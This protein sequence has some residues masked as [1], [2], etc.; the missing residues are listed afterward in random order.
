MVKTFLLVNVW[1]KRQMRTRIETVLR[2]CVD[3]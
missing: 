1:K 2:H 3:G